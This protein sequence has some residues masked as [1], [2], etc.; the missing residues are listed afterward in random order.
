MCSMMRASPIS[1]SG[2]SSLMRPFCSPFS[3]SSTAINSLFFTCIVRINCCA[4]SKCCARSL[5]CM[6]TT[7]TIWVYYISYIMETCVSS[8]TILS[9]H[10]RKNIVGGVYTSPPTQE[11][12]WRC[13]YQPLHVQTKLRQLAVSVGQNLT[14]PDKMDIDAMTRE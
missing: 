8:A 11:Y 3:K 2:M 10:R 12:S 6:P 1:I 7:R 5:L 13:P 9:R 4:C 14:A